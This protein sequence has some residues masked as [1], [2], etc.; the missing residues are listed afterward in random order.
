MSSSKSP[1]IRRDNIGWL[2]A[3]QAFAIAPLLS[4]LPAWISALWMLAVLWRW[5]ILLQRVGEPNLFLKLVL[6][7]AC[8]AGLYLSFPHQAGLDFM[9]GLLVCA[10]VLKVIELNTRKD[11]LLIIFIGFIAVAAQFLFAQSL[12]VGVY[13][14][15]CCAV[16]LT[17]W[18]TIFYSKPHGAWFKVGR[19]GLLLLHSMPLMVILFVVMPRLGPLW[20]VP[21][22][23]GKGKTGFSDTLSPGDIGTL[24]KSGEPAFRVSFVGANPVPSSLYWRGLVLDD[25][26]GQV[27]HSQALALPEP[28]EPVPDQLE[29]LLEYS[30]ILEP[31]RQ[32]WLF[33]LPRAVYVAST[34]G[35]LSIGNDGIV[36][37]AEPVYR[38]LQ[39]TMRSAR[40]AHFTQPPTLSAVSRRLN[41]QLPPQGD[42]KAR[43]LANQWVLAGLN[44]Q[45]KI[46]QALKLFNESF[47]YTLQPPTLGRHA[48]DDFLFV[49]KRGFCEHFASSFAFL[50]RA[51][52]VPARV[53]VGYQGGRYNDVENY[54]LVSQSDAHAW[55][56]VWLEGSGWTTLDP[57]AAVAPQR[58]EQG[59]TEALSPQDRDLVG[60]D[61][62]QRSAWLLPWQ[63]R[64]DAAGYAWQRWVLNYDSHQQQGLL[65]RLLGGRDAWRLGSAL[66][67]LAVVFG[68]VFAYW[69][70]RQ[71]RRPQLSAEARLLAPLLRRLARQG[72]ALQPGETFAQFLQ[73]LGEQEP[74]YRIPARHLSRL[75]E[76]W[77]Y[78]GDVAVKPQ[79]LRHLKAFPG[80][81]SKT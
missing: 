24:V 77:V 58:I 25:Y 8:V 75:F 17:A 63:K 42:P 50:M 43:Q 54:L 6:T 15:L 3:S 41:T 14:L 36:Q 27:W 30:V 45:Q 67:A 57:T 23:D 40:Q 4:H 56:E 11:G 7:S 52:G 64:W 16:L 68:V 59:L 18:Q 65:E 51:A 53:L 46:D 62:W 19:G 13:G 69:L 33:S 60:G 47:T 61:A 72:M 12:L 37:A 66:L 1:L 29:D 73:R 34:G 76:Q 35:E 78:Q 39:Y 48:V 80:L 31:H 81:P 20:T 79:L 10:F 74:R 55:V 26:D 70:L 5:L 9:V 21:V 71:R 2:L 49:S 32:V 38:R 28:D 44:D 22:P